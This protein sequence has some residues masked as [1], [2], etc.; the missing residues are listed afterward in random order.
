[1]RWVP[2]RE[3]DR[4]IA[5]HHRH[6]VP[7]QGGIVALG[8][9]EAEKLVGVAVLGRPLSRVLQARNQAEITRLCVL[10]EAR[11][12]ASALAARARRA[13]QA[14]GFDRV[15]TYTLAEEGGASLRAAGF[16][17]DM[18]LTAGGEWD[19]PSLR[20]NAP[21]HPISRKVRW[22]SDL[23]QQQDLAL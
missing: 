18:E 4:F 15:V 10:S 21:L 11:H 23:R 1:M 19:R 20:R 9:C 14:L 7:A 8:L 17:Q 2:L 16:Q 5:K 6:H 22:W 12:A 3:A 13:A